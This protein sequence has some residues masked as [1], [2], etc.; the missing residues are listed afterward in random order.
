MPG[1]VV[2]RP[3]F[4]VKGCVEGFNIGNGDNQFSF[5]V[6]VFCDTFK[7][8]VKIIDVFQNMPKGNYPEIF[9]FR[10]ILYF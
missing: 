10:D 7:C 3:V 8:F 5:F 6:K 9:V 1:N 2:S 4:M